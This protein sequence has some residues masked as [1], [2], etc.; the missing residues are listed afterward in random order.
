MTYSEHSITTTISGIILLSPT[1]MYFQKSSNLMKS[2]KS[3]WM[4][5]QSILKYGQYSRLT[6]WMLKLYSRQFLKHKLNFSYLN[7][8]VFHLYAWSSSFCFTCHPLLVS[9]AI[10]C[11]FIKMILKTHFL[12]SFPDTCISYLWLVVILLNIPWLSKKDIYHIK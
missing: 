11:S 10:L 4:V 2:K 1:K 9:L 6:M 8:L 12:G 3:Y 7:N 5:M